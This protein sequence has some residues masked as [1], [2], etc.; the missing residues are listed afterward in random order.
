[1]HRFN[2]DPRYLEW[3]RE[4]I[5]DCHFEE[6]SPPDKPNDKF[7]HIVGYT[8]HTIDGEPLIQRCETAA[9]MMAKVFPELKAVR[10]YYYPTWSDRPHFHCWCVDATG[11]IV[12]PTGRQFDMLHGVDSY[13][14]G[15]YEVPPLP[16]RET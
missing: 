8:S 3:I 10:G 16:G 13:R 2:D 7:L 1:V 6:F 9:P 15:K 4:V 11:A 12:D 5:G 14:A